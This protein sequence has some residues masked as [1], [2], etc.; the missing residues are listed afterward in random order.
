M[1]KPIT[2]NNSSTPKNT[3]LGSFE[4]QTNAEVELLP[5]K[6]VPS[7]FSPVYDA[8]E[9][10]FSLIFGWEDDP[11]RCNFSIGQPLDMDVPICIDLNRFVERSNGIFGK[12]GTGK[13]FLTRVLI[14]GIIQQG[15]SS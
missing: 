14:S 11:T 15:S 3:S 6:T 2:N 1:N 4:A 9:S 8:N 7:H 12:S 13:S 10:D 5:V